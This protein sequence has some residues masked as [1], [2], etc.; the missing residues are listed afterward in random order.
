MRNTFL[1][2]I[3]LLI[4]TTCA[5]SQKA[6]NYIKLS[7]GVE[8]SVG[9]SYSTSYKNGWGL[10]VTGY[11]TIKSG[12]VLVS[13]GITNWHSEFNS[14]NKAGIIMLR[15]G[16]YKPLGKGLYIQGDGGI[17]FGFEKFKSI[18]RGVFGGGLGYLF[19]NKTGGGFDISVRLNNG[20]GLTW[21]GIGAG[22]QF[23]L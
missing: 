6:N 14:S 4:V 12:K 1:T 23:K 15:A 17:G 11:E 7:G 8:Y 20:F 3:L 2:L 18:T 16:Y 19:E 5:I 21:A 13:G 22:Y 9:G 10:Y